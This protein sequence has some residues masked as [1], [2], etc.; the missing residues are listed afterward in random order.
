MIDPLTIFSLIK[1]F[2]GDKKVPATAQTIKEFATSKS[3]LS[4]TSLF[5]I[6]MYMFNR[7]SA[8]ET[9]FIVDQTFGYLSL[10][11]GITNIAVKDAIV[12]IMKARKSSE[13]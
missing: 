10:L 2:I 8:S 9:M 5:A 1:T 3:N 13:D 11:F 12:K 4:G 7:E 6:A